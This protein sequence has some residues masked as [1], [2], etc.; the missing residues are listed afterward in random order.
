MAE[1]RF[2][3]TGLTYKRSDLAGQD[4][5][6]CTSDGMQRSA[7]NGKRDAN[8]LDPQ[9]INTRIHSHTSP[10]LAARRAAGPESETN[11]LAAQSNL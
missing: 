3:G 9:Q 4:A 6:I 8:I 11:A 7:D 5:K 2:S 10:T 1:N